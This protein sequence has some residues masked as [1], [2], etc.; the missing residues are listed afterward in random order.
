MDYGCLSETV[1]LYSDGPGL[2]FSFG[3]FAVV[4]LFA[5]RAPKIHSRRV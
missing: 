3:P 5:V 2:L 4:Y 1:T